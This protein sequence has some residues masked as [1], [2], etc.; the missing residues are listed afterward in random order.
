ML[1]PSIEKIEVRDPRTGKVYTWLKG[2]GWDSEPQIS[3][4]TVLFDPSR[5]DPYASV[6]YIVIHVYL[7]GD[8]E[9]DQATVYC[10]VSEAGRVIHEETVT[11]T[12]IG[13]MT[14]RWTGFRVDYV[15]DSEGVHTFDIYVEVDNNTDSVSISVTAYKIKT[16]AVVPAGINI[17]DLDANITWFYNMWTGQW[18]LGTQQVQPPSIPAGH[19]LRLVAAVDVYTDFP[20][21]TTIYLRDTYGN[22]LCTNTQD[23]PGYHNVV[24]CEASTT[25]PPEGLTLTVE[26]ILTNPEKGSTNNRKSVSIGAPNISRQMTATATQLTK[27]IVFDQ[28]TPED[29]QRIVDDILTY[30]VKLLERILRIRI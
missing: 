5:V 30:V 28:I 9:G 23:T 20:G 1:Y 3:I 24:T 7:N 8:M 6:S 27:T 29:I 11:R 15:P 10:R 21:K 19:R 25:M 16:F 14:S 17:T 13:L 18:I 26:G 12:R 4:T 2:R 22:I